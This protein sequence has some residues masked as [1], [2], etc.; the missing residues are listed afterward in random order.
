MKYKCQK[1]RFQWEGNNDT[2]FQ[3]IEH[4]RIHKE[5]QSKLENIQ[6][7]EKIRITSRRKSQLHG[8]TINKKITQKKKPSSNRKVTKKRSS[9]R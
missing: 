1:C 6:R 9:I 8:K 4:E 7:N 5:K 3:V 2:F